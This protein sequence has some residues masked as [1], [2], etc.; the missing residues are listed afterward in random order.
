MYSGYK[1]HRPS[2]HAMY[3]T[4]LITY[5]QI[6]SKQVPIRIRPAISGRLH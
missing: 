1:Q 4:Q 5:P 2:T 3:I 6:T